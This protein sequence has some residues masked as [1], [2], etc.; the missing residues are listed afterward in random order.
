LAGRAAH[1][2]IDFERDS[3]GDLLVASGY[4]A[5]TAPTLFLWEGVSYYLPAAAVDSVLAS[6][7]ALTGPGSSLLFDYVTQ[8]FFDGD[9]RGYGAKL[10]ARGWQSLG[11]VNRSGVADVGALVQPHGFRV[12][13]EVDAQALERLYLHGLRG[14]VRRAWGVM[15]IALVERV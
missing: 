5:Q 8:A 11:N 2:A 7:A 13:S 4:V 15:R 12:R 9:H 3:L 6:V 1:A 14:G 10:L